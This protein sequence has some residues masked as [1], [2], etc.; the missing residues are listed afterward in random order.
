MNKTHKTSTSALRFES[1]CCPVGESK[2]M[3]RVSSL[4]LSSNRNRIHARHTQSPPK[5]RTQPPRSI[6]SSP[7]ALALALLLQCQCCKSAARKGSWFHSEVRGSWFVGSRSPNRSM[8]LAELGPRKKAEK[9]AQ[10]K[11]KTGV[12]R[13][14]LLAGW[15]KVGTVAI[16]DHCRQP[17][18]IGLRGCR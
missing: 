6:A 14:E 8:K 4:P 16:V 11:N 17:G 5:H 1:S 10:Q 2:T 3:D 9:G 13:E 12:T 18:D 7:A 15:A